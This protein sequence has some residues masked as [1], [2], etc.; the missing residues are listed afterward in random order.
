MSDEVS[1]GNFP[2][3]PL[4]SELQPQEKLQ[5]LQ[6]DHGMHVSVWSSPQLLKIAVDSMPQP[7]H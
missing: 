5:D 3:D 4:D 2:T 7:V 6:S 1:L